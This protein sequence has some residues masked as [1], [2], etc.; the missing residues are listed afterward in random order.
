MDPGWRGGSTAP[1][2]LRVLATSIPRDR[3]GP[4]LLFAQAERLAKRPSS[5]QLLGADQPWSRQYR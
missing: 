1:L 4:W 5:A 2:T 3:R